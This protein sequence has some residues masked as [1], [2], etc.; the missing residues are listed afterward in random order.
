MRG[1]GLLF[2]L[3]AIDTAR[4]ADAARKRHAPT[5]PTVDRDGRPFDGLSDAASEARLAAWRAWARRRD[6]GRDA[7][8]FDVVP[9]RGAAAAR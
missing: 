4:R 7:P 5:P 3:D 2:S 8:V 9:R 6:A 1:L